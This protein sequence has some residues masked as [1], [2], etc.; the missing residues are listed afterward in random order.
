MKKLDISMV[1]SESGG[2]Y[3]RP[4]DEPCIAQSCQRLARFTG[5]TPDIDMIADDRGYTHRD[6]TPYPLKK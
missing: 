5:L 6:G 4:F 3:P 1:P 2:T